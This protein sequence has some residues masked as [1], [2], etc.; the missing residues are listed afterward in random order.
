M[1]RYCNLLITGTPGT[2]KT[3]LCHELIKYKPSYNYINVGDFAKDKELYEEYDED[4]QCY[5]LDED[6]LIEEL[7]PLMNRDN[8]GVII[9]YHGCDLFPVQWFDAVFVLRSSNTQLFDRLSE[10]GYSQRKLDE[11]IE[12]EIFQ[13]ILDEAKQTFDDEIVI[14]LQSDYTQDM[15]RNVNF[16]L[17]WIDNWNR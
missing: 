17:E 13:V 1:R 15:E 8:G 10:R 7:T 16:I 4:Y 6:R 2:G 12:S 9:D 11:N 3:S 5:V 14:E